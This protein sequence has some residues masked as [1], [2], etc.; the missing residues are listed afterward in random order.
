MED[1]ENTPK[2]GCGAKKEQSPIDLVLEQLDN[3]IDVLSKNLDKLANL[4]QPVLRDSVPQTEGASGAV[5]QPSQ[6][7]QRIQKAATAIS[8][9]TEYTQDLQARIQI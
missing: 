8:I 6:I 2:T 3:N 9:M 5:D 1:Y 7:G 4:M